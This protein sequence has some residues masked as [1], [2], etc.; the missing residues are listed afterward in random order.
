MDLG[1]EGKKSIVTG[2]SR[3]IGKA[4]LSPDHVGDTVTDI[5]HGIGQDIQRG[6]VGPDNDEILDKGGL[7]L[8]SGNQ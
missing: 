5:V 8:L 7:D 2:G 6:V 4:V 1:L 3:G